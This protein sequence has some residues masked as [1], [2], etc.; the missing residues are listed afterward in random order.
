MGAGESVADTVA[1][2]QTE[3]VVLGVDAFEVD[4]YIGAAYPV[5]PCTV[6]DPVAFHQDVDTVAA[7]INLLI[8][9]SSTKQHAL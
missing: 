1:D 2:H 6:V 8:H 9:Y 5:V 3:N 7:T 4:P